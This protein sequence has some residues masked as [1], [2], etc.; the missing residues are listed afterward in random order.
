[1]TSL[2]VSFLA[3]LDTLSRVNAELAKANAILARHNVRLQQSND[4]LL[5]CCKRALTQ[6]ARVHPDFAEQLRAAIERATNA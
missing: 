5:A 6:S 3:D 4:E 2:E 1:M